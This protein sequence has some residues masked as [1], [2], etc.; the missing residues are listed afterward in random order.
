[1][2]LEGYNLTFEYIK[3]IKNTLADAVSRLVKILP[4]A[5]LQPE[6]E[7]F[8]FGEIVVKEEEG[9]EVN[10]VTKER[11]QKQESDKQDPIPDVKIDWHMTNQEIAKLQ[12]SDSYCQRQLLSLQNGK[13]KKKN[14]FF[15][16]EGLLH[17]YV[18][19]YKQRFEAL[20]VPESQAS[21]ILKLAHD[22][23]GH[24][25]TPRTYALIK[26]MFYWKGLKKSVEKYVAECTICQKHNVYPVRYTPGQFQVPEA[27][28]DFISMD[29]IGKFPLGSTKG[30]H[31]ALTVI[32]MLTGFTWCI[33]IPDK[34]SETIVRAYIKEV[35]SH[36]GGSRKILS[37]NGTEFK[38]DLFRKVAKELNVEYK[39]YSPPY[40]PP[41]NGRIEGFHSFLKA[42]LAKHITNT[43]EWDDLATFACAVYNFLP[44]E[45]S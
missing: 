32:C 5:E 19:D 38:N 28:M 11:I 17:R 35:Y 15:M 6:P 24:N 16:N 43:M 10:E 41:S 3:G 14:C 36:Y 22:D 23:L 12:R 1:M 33:P 42:C 20:V 2:E 30:N 9:E 7:G 39:V 8:E 29:L 31:F 13:V 40:H 44:N 34:N 26:R 45:H 4:D 21:L 37:D 27:L 25:G 18:T